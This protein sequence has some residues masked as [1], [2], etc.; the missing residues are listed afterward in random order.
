MF[1]YL[2]DFH[3]SFQPAS[4][5]A[6][7]RGERENGKKEEER[8]TENRK[9]ER[10]RFTLFY[11]ICINFYESSKHTKWELCRKVARCCM[12]PSKY[13]TSFTEFFFFFLAS[14]QL[15]ADQNTTE[16][17]S[18]THNF[19]CVDCRPIADI[20]RSHFVCSWFHGAF[21]SGSFSSENNFKR[22]V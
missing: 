1:A 19:K 9:I 17:S 8:S 4:Q 22:I 13:A 7:D 15:I 10:F 21:R 2:L 12:R 18:L 16:K 5:P 3:L 20:V 6:A 14:V 11:F